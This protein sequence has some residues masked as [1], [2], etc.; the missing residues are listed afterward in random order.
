MFNNPL[1]SIDTRKIRKPFIHI[2][3]GGAI[4]VHAEVYSIQ[5]YVIKCVSDMR[6][7]WFSPDSPVSS[8]N[9]TDRHDIT[10]ILLKVALSIINQPTILIH[11]L[12]IFQANRYTLNTTRYRTFLTDLTLEL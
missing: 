4:P 2:L 7:V 6:Q 3:D 10:D 1:I 5:H 9:S 12:S 11:N 8:T